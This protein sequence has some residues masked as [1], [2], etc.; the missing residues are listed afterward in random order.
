VNVNGQWLVFEGQHGDPD[1]KTEATLQQVVEL[2]G[3]MFEPIHL[4]NRDVAIA[5]LEKLK[6]FL[7]TITSSADHEN[8]SEAHRDLQP[9]CGKDGAATPGR[10]TVR[11]GQRAMIASP[12][13]ARSLADN[14][15]LKTS[16]LQGLSAGLA[17]AIS[18]Q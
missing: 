8:R 10:S 9:G 16:R 13:N 2:T 7:A 12:A 4:Q 17:I 14:A 15:R 5:Q 3:L 1:M 11:R 6:A 18:G